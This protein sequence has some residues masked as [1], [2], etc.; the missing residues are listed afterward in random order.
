MYLFID[1]CLGVD[2][3][4][5]LFGLQAA[6]RHPATATF[7]H[8]VRGLDFDILEQI[9]ILHQFFSVVCFQIFLSSYLRGTR[10][11]RIACF[12][13]NALALRSGCRVK[14]GTRSCFPKYIVMVKLVIFF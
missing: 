14:K 13:P 6:H 9:K 11:A 5:Q 10:A 2:L 4:L 1:K 7:A 8:D 3:G 12:N